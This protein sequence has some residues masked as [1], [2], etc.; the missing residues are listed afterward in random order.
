M[1]IVLSIVIILATI[2]VVIGFRGRVVDDHPLCRRCGFDLIGRPHDSPRC[3][4]CGARV[5]DARAIRIG[6]RQ[7]RGGWI[8]GGFILLVPSALFLAGVIAIQ[9]GHVDLSPY[10]PVWWLRMDLDGGSSSQTLALKEL[11]TRAAAGKLTTAQ[12]GPIADRALVVQVNS[13]LWQPSWGQFI[14]A[15]QAGGKLDRPRWAKYARQAMNVSLKARKLIRPGDSLPVS[16]EFPTANL[17]RTSFV[18]LFDWNDLRIDGRPAGKLPNMAERTGLGTHDGRVDASAFGSG[19]DENIPQIGESD[20]RSFAIGEHQVRAKLTLYLYAESDVPRNY[21]WNNSPSNPATLLASYQVDLPAK[22]TVC[23]PHDEPP[24]VTTDESL[25]QAV[26]AAVEVDSL[27][28]S[29]SRMILD[30]DFND[31]PVRLAFDEYLRAA[32]GGPE[33]K[34]DKTFTVP[35]HSDYRYMFDAKSLLGGATHVDVILRPNLAAARNEV[36]TAPI[37]GGEIIVRNVPV[38]HLGK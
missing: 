16:L 8:A 34:V 26:E 23:D 21:G 12:V 13:P 37:W 25:R 10:K 35:V 3:S 24:M 11:T 15:A 33:S 17:G 6:H 5:T 28:S 31:S 36:D 38:K 1:L 18:A 22:F 2:A 14:E 19:F 4:E 27:V 7:R 29:P 9:A 30:I 32:D 20:T